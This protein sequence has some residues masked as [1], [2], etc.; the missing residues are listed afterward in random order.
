MTENGT[1]PAVVITSMYGGNM[2]RN[3]ELHVPDHLCTMHPVPLRDEVEA[4]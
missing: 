1:C 2:R 3:R 4:V